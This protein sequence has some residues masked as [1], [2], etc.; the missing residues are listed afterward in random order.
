MTDRETLRTLDLKTIDQ[1]HAVVLDLSKNCFELKKLCATVL[2]SA[3]VLIA[4][5]TDK[6]LDYSFLG[7]GA[8]IIGFFWIL[9][10]QSYFYQDKL[11]SIMKEKARAIVEEG[12]LKL[13]VEGVGVPLATARTHESRL[14]RSF[15]NPSMLFYA[16]LAL[17]DG[18]VAVLYWLG[19]IG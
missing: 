8:I 6:K 3:A 10:V 5:F 17:I 18:G 14:R 9:D 2:V 16:F 19:A 7:A 4:T 13:E 15:F 11:R 1:L 12:K